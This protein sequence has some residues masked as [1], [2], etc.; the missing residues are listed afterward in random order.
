MLRIAIKVIVKKKLIEHKNRIHLRLKSHKC[1]HN[2]CDKSFVTSYELNSHIRYKHSTE[3]PFKC[4][5]NDCNQRLKS[6]Y[7][8]NKHFKRLH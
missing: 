4:I 2:N 8:M 7:E 1:F 5:D 3:K 6:K